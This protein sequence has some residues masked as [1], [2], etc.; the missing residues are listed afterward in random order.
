M[1]IC[2]VKW[3][4]I[5]PNIGPIWCLIVISK[6]RDLL[7]FAL[8]YLQDD[9]QEMGLWSVVFAN[10]A[11]RFSTRYIKVTKG[12]ILDAV[13]LICPAHNGFHHELAFAIRINWFLWS[14]FKNRN[15]FW[16]TVSGSS[17]RKDDVVHSTFMHDFQEFDHASCIVVKIFQWICH[18]LSDQWV[19]R[20][21]DD[22]IN[23]CMFLKNRA[24]EV[25][26][27]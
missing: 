16:N 12:H 20:K 19:G 5:V 26:I 3:M 15:L 7:A 23:I 11:V 17:W 13:C 25:L 9:W 8:G 21:V 27:R 10:R 2:Q 1:S 14:G 18:R 22:R 4:D 24:H 6:N